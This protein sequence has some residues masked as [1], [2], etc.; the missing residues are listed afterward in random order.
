ML[1]LII[2][3]LSGVSVGFRGVAGS[4]KDFRGFSKEHHRVSE[5]F[6]QYSRALQEDS[7][8]F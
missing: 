1:L 4:K 5:N 6:Q 3:S 8:T 2:G 7:G